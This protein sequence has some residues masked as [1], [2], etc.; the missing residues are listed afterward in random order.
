MSYIVWTYWGVEN[1][2]PETFDTLDEV[3]DHITGN[4]VGGRT[5]KITQEVPVKLVVE[6]VVDA[7]TSQAGG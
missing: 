7:I 5:F 1:W 6:N 4:Q 3:Y 2:T